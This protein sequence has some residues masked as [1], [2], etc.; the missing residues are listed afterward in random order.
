MRTICSFCNTTIR[1]GAS[2][3]EPASHGVCKSCYEQILTRYRLNIRKFLD[4]LDA[5]V[6]LV[7]N[8]VN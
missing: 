6:L 3:D 4:M 2:P 7:D 1:P 5:P 8:D